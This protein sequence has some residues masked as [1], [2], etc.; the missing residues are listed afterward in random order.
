VVKLLVKRRA[1]VSLR[2]KFGET[3]RKAARDRGK[4]NVVEWLDSECYV[5][6]GRS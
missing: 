5:S 3:A 4:E 2:N 6:D 1:D